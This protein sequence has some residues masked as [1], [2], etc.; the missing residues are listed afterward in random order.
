MGN[1]ALGLAVLEVM[2]LKRGMGL[3][4]PSACAMRA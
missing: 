2:R 1:W 4:R 3:Y